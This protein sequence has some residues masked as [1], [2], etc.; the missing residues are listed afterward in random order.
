[1]LH[2]ATAFLSGVTVDVLATLVFHYTNQ[3]RAIAAANVNAL[4]TGLVL[5]VFVDVSKD[6]FLAVPYLFGI[7][8]GGIVGIAL[9]VRLEKK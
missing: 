8:V 1:M 7:W 4:L 5:F 2:S 3:N 6:N 9:K